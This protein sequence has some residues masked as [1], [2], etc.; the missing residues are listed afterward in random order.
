MPMK[1]VVMAATLAVASA[2]A[3][4][5]FAP[6]AMAYGPSYCNSSTC[7]LA[8]T[9]SASTIYFEMPRS[10]AESMVCWIDAEW[11]DGTNRWFKVSTIY[12]TGYTSADQ[13]S[14]QTKVGH[15]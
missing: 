13:V 14:N 9:P 5:S 8:D 15:C 10:T 2:A 6:A 4:V 1:K 12:G 7:D 11:Y 3:V